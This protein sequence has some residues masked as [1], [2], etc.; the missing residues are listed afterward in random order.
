VIEFV[1]DRAEDAR[2]SQTVDPMTKEEGR[3][4]VAPSVFT[5][6]FTVTALVCGLNANDKGGKHLSDIITADKR[7]LTLRGR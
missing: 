1:A 5:Q 2:N 3:F 7:T 6:P 4:F